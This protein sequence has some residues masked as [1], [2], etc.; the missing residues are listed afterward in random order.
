MNAF[1]LLGIGFPVIIIILVFIGFYKIFFK[2]VS[3]TTFYTPFDK[4]T[5][6]TEVEYHEEQIYIAEDDDQ[7]DGNNKYRLPI[8]PRKS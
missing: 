2:K 8:K 3:V 5:G 4:I 1:D 6:Q 7:G